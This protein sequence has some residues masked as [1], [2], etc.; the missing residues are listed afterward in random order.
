MSQST[1]W[2]V[3]EE[4]TRSTTVLCTH[5]HAPA[6]RCAHT[7]MNLYT[8]TERKGYIVVCVIIDSISKVVFFL[9]QGIAHVTPGH[10]AS[11]S[12]ATGEI[13]PWEARPRGLKAFLSHAT[14]L[15]RSQQ[16]QIQTLLRPP[17]SRPRKKRLRRNSPGTLPRDIFLF[18]S[19]FILTA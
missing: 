4:N 10:P 12:S 11:P 13:P 15:S 14:K 19:I 16:N 6:Y 18:Q 1:R 5:P 17:L 2:P 3:T 9:C 8:H 7:A